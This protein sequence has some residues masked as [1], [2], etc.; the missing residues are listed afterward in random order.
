[1]IARFSVNLQKQPY[2]MHSGALTAGC[3]G[4]PA[5]HLPTGTGASVSGCGRESG[6]SDAETHEH[7]NR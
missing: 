4:C 3:F 6:L 2:A 5:M 1:M 7:V